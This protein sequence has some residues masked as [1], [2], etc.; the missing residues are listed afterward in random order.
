MKVGHCFSETHKDCNI[1]VPWSIMADGPN[2][3]NYRAKH[4]L[5]RVHGHHQPASCLLLIGQARDSTQ[6][7]GRLT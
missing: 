1:L 2:L 5:H 4:G 7:L 6:W 3:C